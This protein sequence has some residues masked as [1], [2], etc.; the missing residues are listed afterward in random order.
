[1]GLPGHPGSGVPDFVSW[2]RLEGTR[3]VN[4]LTLAL[5]EPDL[6]KEAADE[7]FARAYERWPRVSSM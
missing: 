6:A 2:Y 3:L 1:M 4:V 5:A 7:A